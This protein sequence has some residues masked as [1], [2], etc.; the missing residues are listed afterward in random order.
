MLTPSLL[1]HDPRSLFATNRTNL[2]IYVCYRNVTGLQNAFPSLKGARDV[3][4]NTEE[5]S[6][7]L[8]KIL[9]DP[10]SY[11]SFKLDLPQIA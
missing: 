5:K 3:F 7:L 8:L 11:F 1:C 9:K 4:L 6:F 10:R 2:L